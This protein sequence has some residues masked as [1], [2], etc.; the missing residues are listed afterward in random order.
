V[1][2]GVDSVEAELGIMARF[3]ARISARW[4]ILG[5]VTL[6]FL[7]RSHHARVQRLSLCNYCGVARV[8]VKAGL[9]REVAAGGEAWRIDV[10]NS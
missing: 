4:S 7:H 1:D 2:D 3:D 9:R 10:A 8:T 6:S 5:A